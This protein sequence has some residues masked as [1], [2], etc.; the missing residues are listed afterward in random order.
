[1]IPDYGWEWVRSKYAP[2]APLLQFDL[3]PALGM[4]INVICSHAVAEECAKPSHAFRYS[5]PKSY[6]IAPIVPLIGSQS[7]LIK[8]EEDW[9]AVRKT[10][11][12]G[13][14]PTHLSSL[15]PLIVDR[16]KR[17]IT[18]LEE[19]AATG[20][21]FELESLCTTVTFDIIAGV[22]L[23]MDVNAQAA[24]ADRHPLVRGYA[25]LIPL[26]Q[27]GDANALPLPNPLKRWRRAK[28][29]KTV[30]SE[31]KKAVTRTYEEMIAKKDQ[32]E[33]T[34]GRSVVELAVRDLDRLTPEKLQEVADQVKTF[35]FA[36]HDT[37]S[38]LLQW[39]FYM[40]SLHPHV[41]EKLFAELDDVFGPD[42]SPDEVAAQLLE[43]G[44]DATKRLQYTSAI[45]KET[46]R[47]Y[48][49]AGSAR[50][51]TKENAFTVTDPRTGDQVPIFGIVYLCHYLIHRDKAA[52]GP[53][54]DQW[55]PERWL[56]NTDTSMDNDDDVKSEKESEGIP[57]SAW[58]PFER[59]PRNCI[60]QELANIEARVILACAARKFKFEK[61]GLGEMVLDQDGKEVLDE[62][63]RCKVKSELYTRHR[64]T[65]KPFDAMKGIISIRQ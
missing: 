26:F 51:V 16:T 42:S 2:G 31:I 60:G 57:I 30:D 47:C 14:A 18:N 12:P 32:G 46:L 9:K 45:I 53:T 56:G 64:V 28:L 52:Y 35:L 41:R 21:V 61:T 13:F 4:P 65:F 48:S 5:L 49:P 36:G 6:T 33:D 24:Y 23:N 38:T 62:N 25:D 3:R 59:G 50:I 7:L 27:S 15:L 10:F 40:L 43:S 19:K 8:E 37:T 22:A 54:A 63:G 17:F 20:E 1:M 11:N 44:E 39:I 58:R 55:M 34:D 29:G